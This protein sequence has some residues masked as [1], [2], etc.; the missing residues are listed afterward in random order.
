M[1]CALALLVVFTLLA[2]AAVRPGQGADAAL[3]HHTSS[4]RRNGNTLNDEDGDSSD[5]IEIY[6]AGTNA[7]SLDGWY[8]TDATNNLRKWRYPERRPLLEFLS[9]RLRVVKEP[10]QWPWRRC[11]RNFGLNDSGEYLGLVQPDGTNVVSEFA[12]RFPRQ[13]T[14]RL[15]RPRARYARHARILRDAHAA[16]TQFPP[17]ARASP[18][19]WS[20]PAAAARFVTPFTLQLRVDPPDTNAV[21]RYTLN[22]TMPA[23]NST[24]YAGPIPISA[25]TQVRA[26]AFQPG[27]L[28]GPTHSEAYLQLTAET[29]GFSS[30]LP[31][32]VIHT[33]GNGIPGSGRRLRLSHGARADRGAHADHGSADVGFP[34]GHQCT[35]LEHTECY[36]KQSF[37]VE[38]WGRNSTSTP[39]TKCWVCPRNP[40]SFSMRRTFST[41]A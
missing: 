8:L 15:L 21:I 40:I 12:P 41:R 10:H 25:S 20:S 37:A 18:A 1:A 23:S 17:V 6:N 31:V 14:G 30:D 35:W 4:W 33:F 16:W 28:P 29:A 38:W 13:F 19:K 27:L 7:V 3:A 5:W 32:V 36:P 39:T 26:R 34:R 22:G 9:H 24:V 11:T 2:G